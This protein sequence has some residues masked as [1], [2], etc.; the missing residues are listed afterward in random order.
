MGSLAFV[1]AARAAY[2]VTRDKDDS[3]G[4][5]RFF[6]PIKNNLGNDRD[7]LAYRLENTFSTN[8]KPVV[9][10]EAAPVSVSAD[11]ALNDDGG[12]EEEDD[13]SEL[14]EAKTWLSGVLASGSLPAKD[15]L[16]QARQ[17]GISKRT[18]DRAKKELNITTS[19]AVGVANGGWTW[20][21]VEGC[22]EAP[23]DPGH[24]NLGNLGNLGNLPKIPE[25]NW[26]SEGG[27]IEGC[28]GCQSSE[29]APPT[30]TATLSQSA[31]VHLDPDRPGPLDLLSKEQRGR[32]MAIYYSRSSGTPPSEKHARAW[33]AAVAVGRA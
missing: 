28:Q 10:W 33:H 22:Q 19:K 5:R 14:D 2:C 6:L 11:E 3:T 26:G 15:V 1:A 20:T 8:G 30:A 17:D 9:K 12:R 32:Y 21:M 24:Q 23:Q 25:K 7:G 18:L 31:N 4:E 16:T 29:S 13:S 27:E